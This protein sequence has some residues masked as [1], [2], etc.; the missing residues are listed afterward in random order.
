M[1]IE[2]DNTADSEQQECVHPVS[3]GPS[4]AVN[5]VEHLRRSNTSALMT[6]VVVELLHS[7][8]RTIFDRLPI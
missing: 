3:G 5:V 8:P 1:E 4:K 6:L 7:F 2:V